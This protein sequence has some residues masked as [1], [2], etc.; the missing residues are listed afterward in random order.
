MTES[1]LVSLAAALRPIVEVERGGESVCV[2]CGMVWPPRHP[3]NPRHD[4]SCPVVGVVAALSALLWR[5]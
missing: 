1:S 2:H 4:P 5:W 3:L